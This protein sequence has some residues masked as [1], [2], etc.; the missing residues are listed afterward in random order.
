MRREVKV[1]TSP[2]TEYL[3]RPRIHAGFERWRRPY[4]ALRFLAEGA[5]WSCCPGE[6]RGTGSD[7]SQ[8]GEVGSEARRLWA[9]KEERVGPTG[10]RS[11][12]V[13]WA[14]G[15]E[16]HL[17]LS[18]SQLILLGSQVGAYPLR[19]IRLVF[20]RTSSSEASFKK[21]VL[22][23]VGVGRGKRCGLLEDF[24]CWWAPGPFWA[25]GC[26]LFFFLFFFS[27]VYPDRFPASRE[28]HLPLSTLGSGFLF[29][30]SAFPYELNPQRSQFL[31]WIRRIWKWLRGW[32]GLGSKV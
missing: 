13:L 5:R 19:T 9:E 17:C 23:D 22:G 12:W 4:L 32:V 14:R 31:G 8:F 29:I 1:L 11:S 15:K 18:W 16:N 28:T 2:S 7:G 27:L 30:F 25:S 26:S 24:G 6:R 3:V 10:P 20:V 21:H